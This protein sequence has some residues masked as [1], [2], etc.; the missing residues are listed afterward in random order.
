MMSGLSAPDLLDTSTASTSTTPTRTKKRST[1]ESSSL[2][3]IEILTICAIGN[4]GK[5]FTFGSGLDGKSQ[6]TQ[7]NLKFQ[8]NVKNSDTRNM[9]IKTI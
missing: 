9:N 4:G 1:D 8:I 7:F 3:K 2:E 6:F 5:L